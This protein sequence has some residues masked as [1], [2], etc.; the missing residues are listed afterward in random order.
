M[1]DCTVEV[2]IGDGDG[3]HPWCPLYEYG[4][5]YSGKTYL[6]DAE[7]IV[8]G[9]VFSEYRYSISP[10]LPEGTILTTTATNRNGSTSEF[11]CSCTIPLLGETEPGCLPSEFR[12]FPP[13]P[14]PS[15]GEVTL[16]YHIPEMTNVHLAVYDMG[17]REVAILT[18]EQLPP[19]IYGIRWDGVDTQGDAV[20]NGS[21]VIGMKAGEF[22]QSHSLTIIR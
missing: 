19:S 12:L 6:G 16:C 9:P 20:P 4:D 1:A 11:G 3:Y 13:A 17:G 15:D 14:N 10:A 18:D 8:A 5:A 2:F 21:Y 7:E 22:V